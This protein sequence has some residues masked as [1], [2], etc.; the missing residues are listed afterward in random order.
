MQ[1][2]ASIAHDVP[3]LRD[4]R[5][6]ALASIEASHYISI[7]VFTGRWSASRTRAQVERSGKRVPSPSMKMWKPGC[8]RLFVIEVD[9]V[10]TGED[11]G[12]AAAG[13]PYDMQAFSRIFADYRKRAGVHAELKPEWDLRRTAATEICNSGATVSEVISIMD[14]K[15]DSRIIDDYAKPVREAARNAAR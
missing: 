10:I 14:H 15:M 2:F 11:N 9:T 3:L 4:N 8:P 7:T 1:S 6:F 12:Q 13:R 5:W